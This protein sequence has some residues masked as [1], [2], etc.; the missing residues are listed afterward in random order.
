MK[1]YSFE[2]PKEPDYHVFPKGKLLGDV[3][4]HGTSAEAFEAIR[5]GGFKT[6]VELGKSPLVTVSFARYAHTA[7][8]HVCTYRAA[9]VSGVIIAVKFDPLI[10]SAVDAGLRRWSIRTDGDVRYLGLMPPTEQGGNLIE[11]VAFCRVPP[12]YRHV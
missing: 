9:G 12:E 2:R 7:L 8:A 5:V 3:W 4:Y 11:V 6:G 10:A 1:E